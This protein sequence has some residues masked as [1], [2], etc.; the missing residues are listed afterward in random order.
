MECAGWLLYNSASSKLV[1]HARFDQPR[2]YLSC[3]QRSIAKATC[4]RNLPCRAD[5]R[6]VRKLRCRGRHMHRFIRL[7]CGQ[8][9]PSKA[10]VLVRHRHGSDV[11]MSTA[12]QLA[13]PGAGS[14]SPCL[15]QLHQCTAAVD[16]QRA[17]VDVAALADAQ[18]LRLATAGV[19]TRHQPDPR[20][21]L[22]RVLEVARVAGAGHE[23]AGGEG[24][25]SWNRLQPTAD[26]AAAMPQLDLTLEFTHCR[27]SS[28]RCCSSRSISSLKRPGSSLL[29]SSIRSGT[30]S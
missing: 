2:S 3:H 17:K 19:L 23:R 5:G 13:Q 29:A 11:V 25:D 6:A 14:V 7:A 24:S 9:C 15:G 30:R 18:K 28:L 12:S 22:P 16:Q 8:Q 26:L 21:E 4:G 10:R 1:V 20:C 27:S